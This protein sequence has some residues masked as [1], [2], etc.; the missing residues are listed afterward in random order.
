[1][2]RRELVGK[3]LVGAAGLYSFKA[4]A[5]PLPKAN[6]VEFVR[7]SVMGGVKTIEGQVTLSPEMFLPKQ[8]D[9]AN[10]ESSGVVSD[11]YTAFSLMFSK[12]HELSENNIVNINIEKEY[13][14]S[15]ASFE[16]PSNC[17]IF[18]HGLIYLDSDSDTEY[19]FRAVERRNFSIRDVILSSSKVEKLWSKSASGVLI[20]RCTGFSLSNLDISFR[21]DAIAITSSHSFRV[22]HCTLHDLGEEG[23][24]VRSSSRWMIFDNHIYNHNGDGILLKTGS[25]DSRDGKVIY[26]RVHGGADRYGLKGTNGGGITLNDEVK[27]SSTYFHNLLVQGNTVENTSYGISFTNIENLKV[28]DNNI[29]AV[30]RF[31]IVIDNAVYNNP[32]RHS[33]NKTLISGNSV[34]YTQQAGISFSS[35]NGVDVENT[36][37]SQN[38]VS[39]CALSEKADFPGISANHATISNNRVSRCRTLLS[40]RDCVI[41]GNFFSDSLKSKSGKDS[42]VLKI[43]GGTTFSGNVVSEKNMGHI[44]LG[45]VSGS[46]FSGNRISTASGFAVFYSEVNL[47]DTVLFKDNIINN[48]SAIVF[49]LNPTSLS[50]LSCD[51]ESLGYKTTYFGL[52][53]KGK[54]KRGDRAINKNVYPGMPCEWVCTKEGNPGEWQIDKFLD[55]VVKTE[56]YKV[57]VAVGSSGEL[58]VRDDRIKAGFL[59]VSVT[60]ALGVPGVIY[61]AIVQK[62]GQAIINIVNVGK[63]TASINTAF[64][65]TINS[66]Y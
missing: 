58:T 21:T 34:Q 49:K 19:F 47:T 24:V 44:M 63:E 53:K 1:M 43:G 62:A 31:G 17:H 16:L 50:Y 37:I 28:V 52:P 40:A 33:S 48:D 32:Q 36:I 26:N 51:H 25:R 60:P 61:S 22:M 3:F 54:F 23:I 11:Y 66:G 59:V 38:F 7:D 29:T 35:Q 20:E 65:L 4:S 39:D 8:A 12:A 15:R 30:Q 10:T 57:S 5:E 56:V 42:A 13:R 46:I 9:K 41:E 2:N 6:Q 27:G 14:L 18:G 55:L 64:I 45:D